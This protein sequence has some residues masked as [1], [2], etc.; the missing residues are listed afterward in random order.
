MPLIVNHDHRRQKVIEATCEILARSGLDAVTVRDVAKAAGY[1][2]SVV[3]HYFRGKEELLYLT[4]AS[5]VERTTRAGAEALS[6]SGGDLKASLSAA[7]PLDDEH[8]QRWRVW[9]AY[10]ALV[11][12]KPD[13][14][15]LQH[16]SANFQIARITGILDDLVARGDVAPGQDHELIAR[17][18]LGAVMGL[19]LQVLFDRPSWPPERT[20]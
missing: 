2:T 19:A 13:I 12:A 1:S 9:L 5:S 20:C 7:M 10:I 6:I 18:L 16:D 17:R 14:A 8:F 15:K 4:F 11:V 3:S